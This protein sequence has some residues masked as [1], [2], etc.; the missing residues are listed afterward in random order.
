MSKKNICILIDGISN[1]GGTDR[2][3]AS[4]SNI[5]IVLGNQVSIF[6]LN[7]GMPFYEMNSKVNL[8]YSKSKNRFW[9]LVDAVSHV[10]KVIYDYVIII[11]MGRLSA[12]IIPLLRF[13]KVTSSIICSDH[14]SIESFPFYIRCIKY[15]AYRLS[16]KIVVLTAHDK[17]FLSRWF[18]KDKIHIIRNESPYCLENIDCKEK[19]V[20]A[21]GRL[22]Y[23]KNFHRLLNIWKR[24]KNEEWSLVI[25][26]DG[27]ERDNLRECIESNSIK[28]VTILPPTNELI[29]W[30][31]K[32]SLLLMT[33]RY[34]GLPMVLI[35]SKS[36]GIPV[37]AFDCKTGPREIIK[38]DGFLIDYDD[39]GTFLKHVENLLFDEQLRNKLARNALKNAY[40]YSHSS[41]TNQWEKI[42]N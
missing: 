41:I 35:E 29:V 8:F 37:I 23:Q 26:G 21:V 4:I 42:I 24:I 30:Y 14:V 12:Q 15:I 31:R 39:D 34:E 3:A 6:S 2:V 25:I 20:I 40:E 1:S 17:F 10:K 28:N 16:S 18:R 5:F 36:F 22:T 7:E 9:K 13:S 38:D 11:S 32:A 33:S 19:V 27:E